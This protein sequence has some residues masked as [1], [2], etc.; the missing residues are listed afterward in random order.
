MPG[1]GAAG[2]PSRSAIE[3]WDT[4]HL[5]SAAQSWTATALLWED[6]FNAVHQGAMRPG[7]TVWEGEAADAAA[8]QTFADLVTVRGASDRLTEAAGIASRGAD[9][10]LYLKRSA[11]AAI[12]DAR[13]DGFV[14]GEDLSVSDDSVLP[15]GPLLA[16]RQ[17]L[18]EEHAAEIHARAAAL[19]LADHVVAA[20]IS[21]ALA[22]LAEVVFDDAQEWTGTVHALDF[23]QSPGDRPR[24]GDTPYK[25]DAEIPVGEDPAEVK[26]WWDGLPQDRKDELLRDWPEQ[27][28]ALDGVPVADRST[29]NTTVMQRDIDRVAEVA[30]ARGV[31]ADE[32]LAHPEKYGMA[33][34]MMDRYR[35]G[36][37]V[38]EALATTSKATRTETFLQVYQPDAFGGDGRAAVAIGD[39]DHAANTAVVVPGTGNSV[40]NGWLANDDAVRLYNEMRLADPDATRAVVAWQGYDAPDSPIDPRIGTTA[41]A[42]EGGQLLAADVNAL[43]VTHEGLGHMTVLGHSYGSTTVADAAAGFGMHTDDVVLIGS[44]GTDLARSAADFHLNPG[45]E[46]YVGAASSDPVTQLGGLPQT[47]VPGAGW[48]VALGTDPALDGYGS[49]RFKAEV[50]GLTFPFSDHSQYYAPRSESLYSMVEIVTGNGEALAQH[51]MTAPHRIPLPL[52]GFSGSID[53]ELVRL[54]IANPT[55]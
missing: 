5:K 51:G 35:N 26:R 4:Q 49:T 48:S 33:G 12:D 39:P 13:A 50:S 53:P 46:L 43:N 29:A 28:G 17:A 23:K 36:L 40:S 15:V 25:T 22:P 1:V 30:A 47:L 27:I 21:A 18:A 32:V 55:H 19:S 6:S 44:P 41:L 24:P 3:G 20:N 7:G 34:P 52:A 9:Q 16:A 38:K 31:T 37:K 42:R 45:G 10:L 8:E 2:I 54:D 14:V 11:L